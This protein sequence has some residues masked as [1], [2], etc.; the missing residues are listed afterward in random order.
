MILCRQK[1]IHKTKLLI[2]F[3][4]TSWEREIQID[5]FQIKEPRN[6]PELQ[7]LIIIIL[8]LE[9][10]P[11]PIYKKKKKKDFKE[12]EELPYVEGEKN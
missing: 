10:L 2:F 5:Y 7:K 4:L 8:S 1:K 11:F 9:T 12:G 6:A 3:F